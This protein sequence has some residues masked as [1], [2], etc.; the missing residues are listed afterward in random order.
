MNILKE[1]TIKEYQKSLKDLKNILFGIQAIYYSTS[2]NSPKDERKAASIYLL[3]LNNETFKVAIK[4]LCVL[5]NNIIEDCSYNINIDPL[6]LLLY[7]IEEI[8]KG[9]LFDNLNTVR[10][11]YFQYIELN[12]KTSLTNI[13]DCDIKKLK[14]ADFLEKAKDIC[15]DLETHIDN[16]IL[17]KEIGSSGTNVHKNTVLDS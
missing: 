17:Q 11:K 13:E 2:P 1:H 12:N 16:I 14:I 7:K 6:I 3:C 4:K 10:D 15:Q 8:K 9:E 5:L